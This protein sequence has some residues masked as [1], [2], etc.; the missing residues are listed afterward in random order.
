MNP[1][2]LIIK[3]LLHYR[4]RNF[5]LALGFAISTAVL[6][7]ALIVGDSV[8]YSLN[9][10]VEQR[11][12]SITMIM[13]SGDRFFTEELSNDIRSGLS[14]PVSGLL[15]VDGMAVADGGQLRI[16]KVNVFGTDRYFDE[17]AGQKEYYSNLSN[18]TVI[19]SSNLAER[20]NLVVGDEFLLRMT[21]ASLVP[22]NAPFVS[23]EDNI[24]SLRVTISAI[25]GLDELGAFNVQNSQTA[26]FNIFISAARLRDLMDFGNRSNMLLVS[27]ENLEASDLKELVKR[28]WTPDDAGLKLRYDDKLK[29]FDIKSDRVFIDD[30]VA[31]GLRNANLD[32]IP[33]L[34][35]FINSI[36][37]GEKSTPYSFISTLP[38]D[39]IGDHE[40]VIN[41]WLADDLNAKPG[42]K[43]SISYFVVG[44]LRELDVARDS[45]TVIKIVPLKGF[46]A[47]K[48]LMPDIPGMSDAG[49]CRDW[50]AGVPIT[51][52]E[53]RDEDEDYWT[54]YKGTPKAFISLITAE[55]L[56]KNRFGTFTSFRV[57]AEEVD[58]EQISY[59]IMSALDPIALGFEFQ[60][61]LSQASY[62]AENGVDFSELFGGLSFF[63]LAGAIILAILLFRLNLEERKEHIETLSAMGIPFRKIRRII[64]NE[65]IIVALIGGLIG[66]GLAILYNRLVFH[67]LNSIWVDIVRTSMLEVNIKILTLLMG[68]IISITIAWIVIYF[69]LKKFLKKTVSRHIKNPN[70][71]NLNT[72]ILPMKITGY[73]AGLGAI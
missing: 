64:A 53:I 58:L 38:E 70:E 54:V 15:A 67:A 1:L 18:D 2:K 16:N 8:Q 24:V 26:P 27:D 59:S 13:K 71:K 45:F 21:K 32:G 51:L 44:P 55:Q 65:S 52:D 50:E 6:T 14:K 41:K 61:V 17:F 68:F 4:K 34:T 36:S 62:A 5:L 46:F 56:W 10:I 28:N 49:N 40:I 60:P 42:D 47:D 33:N 31:T 3:S 63:L 39:E 25:A 19:I 11:L 73:I 66:M 37:N 29:L 48:N 22:L 9:R 35:Y 7:G 69:T 23:D 30:A 12:G 43:I 72:W 57:N 20:L